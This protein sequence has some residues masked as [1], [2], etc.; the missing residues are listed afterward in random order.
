MCSAR[1]VNRVYVPFG[2]VSEFACACFV[3][4]V[5]FGE[6]GNLRLLRFAIEVVDGFA[7][8]LCIS[9]YPYARR[10][11]LSLSGDVGCLVPELIVNRKSVSEIDARSR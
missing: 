5:C 11:T 1:V 7:K 8:R 6:R 3:N 10:Q 4:H 9:T 2:Y